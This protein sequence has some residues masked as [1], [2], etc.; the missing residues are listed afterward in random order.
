MYFRPFF[1]IQEQRS[2]RVLV[3]PA[4][5]CAT[6][7]LSAIAASTAWTVTHEMTLLRNGDIFWIRSGRAAANPARRPAMP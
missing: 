7:F 2:A 4:F 5:R 6:R 1:D 3:Y